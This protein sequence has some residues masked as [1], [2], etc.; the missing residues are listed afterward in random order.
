MTPRI[1]L[2]T[3]NIPLM[4]DRVGEVGKEQVAESQGP[5]EVCRSRLE[6]C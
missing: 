1:L 2:G 6:N 5:A 3:V 4:R